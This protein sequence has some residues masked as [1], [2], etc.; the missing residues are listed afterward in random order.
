MKKSIAKISPEV[1]VVGSVTIDTIVERRRT[2][3]RLGGVVTYGGLTF[4]RLGVATAAVTNLAAADKSI[5]G[6]FADEG[7]AVH[8]GKSP[9]TTRFV[10]E[11]RGD[12]REQRMPHA[13]GPISAAQIEP[14]LATVRHVHAGPLHPDDI[15]PRAMAL[16]GES[17]KIVSLDVQGYLRKAEN[18]RIVPGVSAWL[19]GALHAAHIIKADEG[20]L[21]LMLDHFRES[22]PGF[23]QRFRVDEAV[24]THGSRGASVWTRFGE[25]CHIAAAEVRRPVSTV[26]AGDVFFAAYLAAHLYR[27]LDMDLAAGFAAGVAARQVA[28]KHI[29]PALL[30]LRARTPVKKVR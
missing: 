10:N 20:E 29:A 24:I 9:R 15:E 17:R 25:G 30:D 11:S 2:S 8:A 22:L 27:G 16:I 12:L 14:L 1:L 6:I 26:G 5:L 13:A 18:G 19:G 23:L 21:G 3:E 7:I 4:Q 28:G